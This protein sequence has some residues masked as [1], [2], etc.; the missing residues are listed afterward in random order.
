[1]HIWEIIERDCGKETAKYISELTHKYVYLG[2]HLMRQG[3]A[4]EV[5]LMQYLPF[6]GPTCGL[7]PKL[8]LSR[9]WDQLVAHCN[10]HN[11]NIK[12]ILKHLWA[13]ETELGTNNVLHFVTWGCQRGAGSL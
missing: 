7:I 2:G 11:G 4:K 9:V 6:G 10:R 12:L 3:L 8:D 1:M 13:R 5:L